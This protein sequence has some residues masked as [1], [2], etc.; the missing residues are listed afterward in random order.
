[1]ILLVTEDDSIA[2][3]LHYT[4]LRTRGD[5]PVIS[6]ESSPNLPEDVT[7]IWSAL[8]VDCLNDK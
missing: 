5:V 2:W 4:L 7:S 6:L 3:D 1:M 8:Y